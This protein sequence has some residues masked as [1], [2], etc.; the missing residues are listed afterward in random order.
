MER[1]GVPSASATAGVPSA[2]ATGAGIR[3]WAMPGSHLIPGA[4]FPTVTAPGYLCRDGD[5]AGDR[6][7]GIAG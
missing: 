3:P 6:A 4:G 5:G 1:S 2:W 7:I